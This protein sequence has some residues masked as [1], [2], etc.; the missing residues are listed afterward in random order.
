M[1]NTN[2]LGTIGL[3]VTFISTMVHPD[4]TAD[5]RQAHGGP[6]LPHVAGRSG[7]QLVAAFAVGRGLEPTTAMIERSSGGARGW[8]KWMRMKE[9]RDDDA[10]GMRLGWFGGAGAAPPG[11]RC[12]GRR[13]R[14]S[15]GR[16]IK[17]QDAWLPSARS[18]HRAR[19]HI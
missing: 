12:A 19:L 1:S 13:S 4:A 11:S 10:M 16:A 15:L 8:G 17:F 7:C 5:L 2:S 18:L 6:D 14:S 3:L 9:H